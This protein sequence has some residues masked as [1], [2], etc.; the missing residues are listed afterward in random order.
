MRTLVDFKNEQ[1]IRI[2][3]YF[4][5]IDAISPWLLIIFYIAKIDIVWLVNV[6]FLLYFIYILF[7]VTRSFPSVFLGYLF[8]FACIASVLKLILYTMAS[9]DYELGHVFS[10][11]FGLIMPLAVLSFST[12]IQYISYQRANSIFERFAKTYLLIAA[13][14]VIIY[15][16]LYF[17][18]KIEYFGLGVNLHYIYPWFLA[19]K[20]TPVFLFLFLILISGKRSVLINYLIQTVAYYLPHFKGRFIKKIAFMAAFILSL[21]FIYTQTKLLDRFSWL[22]DGTF[23]FD[24]PYFLLISGGGRF[25]ELFG[26]LD[27]FKIHFYDIFFGSPPGSFY[28]WSMDWSGYDATK[29]YSHITFLGYAFRYGL[30]FSS[31]MYYF[32]FRLI[33][34]R[35]GDI[36][37]C[38][39]VVVGV[40]SSSFF[41][42]NLIID[43]TSWLFIGFFLSRLKSQ[44]R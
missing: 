19:G 9:R 2:A 5:T 41:G 12:R 42:A 4:A 44:R 37:P 27:Y 7:N 26:I 38:Y 43:P 21:F 17:I 11:S 31:L 1:K 14:G 40:V 30:I 25:E 35:I 8:S 24:D 34:R 3:L 18:G 20:F 39:L 16:I 29:N 28:I 23:D 36:D 6:N 13:P 22:F 15:S 10:Y 33:W 32:F